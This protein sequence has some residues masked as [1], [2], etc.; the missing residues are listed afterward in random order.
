M[1]IAVMALSQ[2]SFVLTVTI[3]DN[4]SKNIFPG[5]VLLQKYDNLK[6]LQTVTHVFQFF[7]F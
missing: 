4:T 3:E 7:F 2:L 5:K 6:L 1:I